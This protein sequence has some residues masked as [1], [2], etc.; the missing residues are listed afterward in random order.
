MELWG[1]GGGGEGRRDF[2]GAEERDR[3][4]ERLREEMR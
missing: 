4:M 1:A 2:G 3:E